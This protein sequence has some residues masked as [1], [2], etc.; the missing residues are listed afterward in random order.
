M[1]KMTDTVI[2]YGNMRGLRV[3]TI[4]F[5]TNYKMQ[6]NLLVNYIDFM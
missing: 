4:H 1:L 6:N 3:N 5:S 2:V